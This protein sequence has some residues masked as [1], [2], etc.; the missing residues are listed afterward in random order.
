MLQW[1]FYSR[2]GCFYLVV[3]VEMRKYIGE[4]HQ[5]G[6][7]NHPISCLKVFHWGFSRW[8]CGT[9]PMDVEKKAG[10]DGIFKFT[11]HGTVG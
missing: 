11:N 10:V 4:T 9:N 2:S 6:C 3:Q 5:E 7:S 1:Q 8:M